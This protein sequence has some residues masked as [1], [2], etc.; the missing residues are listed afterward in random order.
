MTA[1]NEIV[2]IFPK[3]LSILLL[4]YI[5]DGLFLCP[6]KHNL[7]LWAGC[8]VSLRIHVETTAQ[9]DGVRRWGPLEMGLG[10]EG[11]AFMND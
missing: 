1:L 5:L 6:T 8:S 11:V 10:L 7:L 4:C 9:C 3:S 2:P